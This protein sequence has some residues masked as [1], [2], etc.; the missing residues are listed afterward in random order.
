[1]WVSD[2]MDDRVKSLDGNRYAQVFANGSFFAEIY[3][4]AT[5]AGADLA[6]KEFCHELGVPDELTIDRSK[7]QNA[8]GM[9]FMKTCH[10]DDIRVTRTELNR[11]N[12]NP[13]EGVIREVLRRWFRT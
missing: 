13:S 7:E 11:P 2:I 4:M 8:L 10:K 6:L 3:P 9:E 1:M 12:Q 5:K